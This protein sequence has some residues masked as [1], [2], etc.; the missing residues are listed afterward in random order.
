MKDSYKLWIG[1]F[2][3]SNAYAMR[4]MLDD[5]FRDDRLVCGRMTPFIQEH[6]NPRGLFMS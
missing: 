6:C 5:I 1:R 4:D 2:A 3:A